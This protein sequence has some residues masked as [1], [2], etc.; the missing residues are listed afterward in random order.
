MKIRSKSRFVLL[1]LDNYFESI[2]FEEIT[3][4]RNFDGRVR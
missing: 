4:S 1:P 3:K 2:P